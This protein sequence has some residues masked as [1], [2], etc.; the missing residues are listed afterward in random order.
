MFVICIY[1]IKLIYKKTFFKYQFIFIKK[2]KIKCINVQC[3][4]KKKTKIT[5][6]LANSTKIKGINYDN[7][8]HST[9][10]H[11]NQMD[12]KE[13]IMAME[14]KLYIYTYMYSY[15]HAPRY[16]ILIFVLIFVTRTEYTQT[17][18]K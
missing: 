8:Q 15:T 13:Y 2:K 18:T 10:T 7:A 16:Y 1:T 4:H 11:E 9:D 14:I 3:V 12:L 6:R 17:I 5:S